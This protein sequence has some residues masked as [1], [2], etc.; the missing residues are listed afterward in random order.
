MQGGAPN[1]KFTVPVGKK[2]T[3]LYFSYFNNERPT[4]RANPDTVA[5]TFRVNLAQ[6]AASG[7]FNVT[8]D[9]IQVRTGYF[10][11]PAIR[12]GRV[13][14]SASQGRSSR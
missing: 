11:T 2:D 13:R 6:T 7:G 9:T 14:W 5:M 4:V 1:R 3:T 8:N 12:A 10:N